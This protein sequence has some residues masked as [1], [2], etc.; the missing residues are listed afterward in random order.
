[1]KYCQPNH[2]TELQIFILDAFCVELHIDHA[3]WAQARPYFHCVKK[4]VITGSTYFD[5]TNQLQIFGQHDFPGLKVLMLR[6]VGFTSPWL[7]LFQN[8]LMSANITELRLVNTF[9]FQTIDELQ[10]CLDQLPR[11]EVF[12]NTGGNLGFTEVARQLQLRF[13]NLRGFGYSVGTDDTAQELKCLQKFENLTEFHLKKKYWCE[14]LYDIFHYV[15]NINVL[16]MWQIE[17]ILHYSFSVYRIEQC[18]NK[19]IV[20]RCA[21]FPS[22]NRI[23]LLVNEGQYDALKPIIHQDVVQLTIME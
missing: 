8:S 1:M 14:E 19:L 22:N 5:R 17:R 3:L 12:I 6:D 9:F 4:L 21:Q 15:P 16:G 7:E 10:N 2:L 20:D 11:L 13:P 18:I 23:R